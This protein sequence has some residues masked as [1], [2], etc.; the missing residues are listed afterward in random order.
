MC[1]ATA[2]A[3]RL[4]SPSLAVVAWPGQ[5][6]DDHAREFAEPLYRLLAAGTI[7]TT[8][9]TAASDRTTSRWPD[10]A[11]P[12]LHHAAAHRLF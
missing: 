2:L 1:D 4:A 12:E 11:A 7:L 9:F 6:H 8:A 3:A 10:V 5:L